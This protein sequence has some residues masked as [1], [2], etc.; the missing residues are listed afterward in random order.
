MAERVGEILAEHRAL[1]VLDLRRT[2]RAL[3]GGEPGIEGNLTKLLGNELDQRMTRVA[4]EMLG[5]DAAAGDGD[6][7]EWSQLF[8]FAPCLTIGGGTSEM[9]RNAIGERMLGLPRDPILP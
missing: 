7:A 2:S 1:T 5:L 3:S 8:L 9:A 4:V 6:A